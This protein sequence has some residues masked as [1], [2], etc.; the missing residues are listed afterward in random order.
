LHL[1][2]R[3]LSFRFVVNRTS[4]NKTVEMMTRYRDNEDRTVAG[5]PDRTQQGKEIAF[6]E[7]LE[8]NGLP[9]DVVRAAAT[10]FHREFES[11]EARLSKARYF[12]GDTLSVLDIAWYVYVR[13]LDYAGYPFER[14]HPRLHAWRQAF[15]EDARFDREVTLPDAIRS[16]WEKNR[17]EQAQNGT[18]FIDVTGM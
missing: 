9:D 14:L 12:L 13:R 6:Y 18:S 8:A 10:K 11:L 2:L 5:R 3:C 16:G 15:D 7:R 4:S 17:A 1:D